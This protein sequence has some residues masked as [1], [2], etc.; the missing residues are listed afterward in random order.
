MKDLDFD[1]LDR[2]VNSLMTNVPKTAPQVTESKE[3]TLDITPTL[4][5]NASPS[6]DKVEA[7]AAQAVASPQ[8]TPAPT[9]KPAGQ[10]MMND[11]TPRSSAPVTAPARPQ[12]S[13]APAARRG[14]KFMDVVRP[15]VVTS[16]EPSKP[17]SR[18]GVTIQPSETV[19]PEPIAPK[20]DDAVALPKPTLPEP[21]AETSAS[22]WP[23]PLDMQTPKSSSIDNKAEQPT[24][25]AVKTDIAPDTSADQTDSTPPEP[26][27]SPF[28]PDAK[29]EKRPLG[30]PAPLP[31]EPTEPTADE[32]ATN[33]KTPPSPLDD[34]PAESTD[35][36]PNEKD[37]AASLQL[38]PT[39]TAVDADAQL[40]EELS[41]DLMA[42]E[43]DTTH[44]ELKKAHDTSTATEQSDTSIKN[45]GP[46]S[47]K[48]AIEPVEKESAPVPTGPTSI[49]QQY[50]E[51]PSTGD[52]DNGS[53]YDTNTYHQP[54]ANT[55]K[56]SS[57]KKV[58]LWIVIII[59][60]GIAAGVALYYSRII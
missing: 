19:A 24:D 5:S 57:G 16:T 55:A 9:P 59:L 10:R 58:I 30:S 2:A 8:P 28:L 53:I 25:E 34:M 20:P 23:D 14:S 45:E 49:A 37:T 41:G 17:V 60:V 39:P 50:H 43:A 27:V 18:Q 26:L 15:T 31:P 56:K 51:S 22:D 21:A 44:D 4:D 6:F 13:Q 1:E 32:N 42:V 38:P 52:K 11:I 12:P 29:V 40:P 46:E 3:K 54:L 47:N 48:S 33:E 35:D 36:I 7:V